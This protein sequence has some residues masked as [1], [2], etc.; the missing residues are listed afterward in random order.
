MTDLDQTSRLEGAVLSTD[1]HEVHDLQN[2]ITQADMGGAADDL[3]EPA[4][5]APEIIGPEVWAQQWGLLHDM[6]GGMVQ[7]RTGQPC[8]LGDQARS[9]GG[10]IAC[11]AAY[12][13]IEMSPAR[14]MI[15]G[16]HS[17]FLGQVLAV[18]VHGFACVQIVKASTKAAAVQREAESFKYVSPPEFTSVRAEA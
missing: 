2:T 14:N 13:L 7:A 11:Q 12:D 4:Y 5:R 10:K 17:S 3:G 1:P 8:A 18:G 6:M 15:L 16:A 9:E